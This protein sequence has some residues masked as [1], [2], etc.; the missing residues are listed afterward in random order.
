MIADISE[1]LGG[2]PE[3]YVYALLALAV[4]QIVVQV[5]ALVDL[6]RVD[7]VVGG[8]KWLWAL[9]IIFVSNFALGAILYFAIGRRVQAPVEEASPE[10]QVSDEEKTERV[11]DALYGPKKG[12]DQ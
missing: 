12:D 4:V 6:V 2:L 5:W 11:L 1:A 3:P 9:L 7:A 8:R 10:Q